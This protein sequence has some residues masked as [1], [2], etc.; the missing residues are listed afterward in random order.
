[1]AGTPQTDVVMCD[2]R[3]KILPVC[4]HVRLGKVLFENCKRGFWAVSLQVKAVCHEKIFR[5]RGGCLSLEVF[6]V[7]LWRCIK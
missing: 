7:F 1:M 2:E 3:C 5:V 4:H 6:F